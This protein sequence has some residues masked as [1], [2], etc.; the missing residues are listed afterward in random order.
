MSLNSVVYNNKEQVHKSHHSCCC[1]CKSVYI[2]F[3]HV[4][5]LIL[6]NTYNHN[7]EVPFHNNSL[8]SRRLF[9]ICTQSNH[10]LWKM[11]VVLVQRATSVEVFQA[12]SKVLQI[13]LELTKLYIYACT[14]RI[15]QVTNW[16]IKWMNGRPCFILKPAFVFSRGC[17]HRKV[18]D[19]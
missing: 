19:H 15:F 10:P 11:I 16:F 13:K 6:I 1:N 7:Y 17:M 4:L 9:F 5:H 2:N 12:S 8:K 14:V 18:G 3:S